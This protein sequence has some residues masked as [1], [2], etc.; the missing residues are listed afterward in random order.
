MIHATRDWRDRRADP[1]QRIRITVVDREAFAAC[2]S[3]AV[4]YPGLQAACELVPLEMDVESPAFLRA[5]W[6]Y[7]GERNCVIDLAYVCLDD[8]AL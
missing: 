4:R 8:D 1:D 7:D 6:L 3:L 5:A 2:E